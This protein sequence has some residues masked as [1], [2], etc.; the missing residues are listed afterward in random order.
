MYINMMIDDHLLAKFVKV[1][2]K[3]FELKKLNKGAFMTAERDRLFNEAAA[4]ATT[5]STS[6]TMTVAEATA[7]LLFRI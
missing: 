1:T 6:T 5:M 2:E 4:A 3:K 7:K